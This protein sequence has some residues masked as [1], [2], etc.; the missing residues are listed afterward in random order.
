MGVIQTILVLG[1]ILAVLK[2]FGMDPILAVGWFFEKF[3][4]MVFRV[5]DWFSNNN[6]F[7]ALFS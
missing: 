4:D 5:A 7:R 6:T 2:M 3:L 1:L